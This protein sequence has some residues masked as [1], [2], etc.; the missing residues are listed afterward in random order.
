MGF[1]GRRLAGNGLRFCS[2]CVC[3]WLRMSTCC[4]KPLPEL[5][6]LKAG[7]R[8]WLQGDSNSQALAITQ[9]CDVRGG[10]SPHTASE[11]LACGAQAATAGLDWGPPAIGGAEEALLLAGASLLWAGGGAHNVIHSRCSLPLNSPNWAHGL[12][13]SH[14]LRMW[15]ALGSNP[16]GPW[17]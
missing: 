11:G 9:R 14:P 2:A 3:A 17:R 8:K 15:K 1:C 4:A 16:R 7:K 13:V 5:P 6:L 10:R 12:V